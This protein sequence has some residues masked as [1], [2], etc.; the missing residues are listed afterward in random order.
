MSAPAP[1]RRLL[2]LAVSPSHPGGRSA[3][4]CHYRC[5]DACSKPVPNTTDN[6]YFGDI[7]AASASR[8]TILK[9]AGLAAAFVGFGAASAM[10][11][12]AAPATAPAAGAPRTRGRGTSPFGFTPIEPVPAGTDKVVVPEGFTWSTIIAWGDPILPGA[13]EFDF[14][15][16]S[17]AA[18][19]GQFGYNNDYTTLI[20]GKSQN[21]ATLVCNNEY[22]ND[23]LMF[24]GYTGSASL[25]PEQI[26]IT[27]AAHG[28]S[29][30]AV[31]RKSAKAEWSYVRGATVNRRVT[32]TTPFVVDGPAAGSR[33]LRTSADPSGTRVLGTFGNCAGGTT[34]WGTVISG[35]ENFNGYF[36]AATAPAD[37]AAAYQRYGL[38]GSKGRGWERVDGRFDATQEPNEVN[39]FGWVVELDPSDPTST[40]VKH[41]AMGRMKHE[42]AN[43]T[44][45]PD[46]R[47]VA[48]MGDD[49][50]FDYLYKFVSRDTF[51][52]GNSPKA[53]KHNLGLLSEGDLYVAKFTGDGFEDGIS[54][55]SG[56]WLAITKDGK[57]QVPGMSLE[58]VLVWTRLAADKLGATKMDRPEDVEP[59]LVNGR[60]YVVCTNN[61]RRTPS[62][63]DEANPRANNKHGHIIEITPTRG[64]DTQPT[65]AWKIVL[66]AGD[67]NDPTTY[68]NGYDRSEVSPISCPDNIAFDEAGNMWIATD[69]NALGAC[70][71]MYLY[72]LEGPHKGHLQQFLSVPAYAETCGPLVTWDQRTVLAAVQHPGEE[73]G[74]SPETPLSQ[75]P[76]Q[77][78]GQPRPAV[79]QI[80]PTR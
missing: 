33:L 46:G 3:M 18:Q 14:D 47:V 24:R 8:R 9:G 6:G 73:T 56:E 27:M 23:E 58:E 70:D 78:D 37:Q 68:W 41:T 31:E 34:P 32:A 55:G 60:T 80:R 17:A 44:I 2:P 40:P 1:E 77:G 35:E 72:P 4:T 76:Y 39:R 79:I 25:T 16:Q 69:G 7:A 11:A 13:P 22:T 50:R 36:S 5:D 61:T 54:D 30:V 71:G 62:Q 51:R 65:F 74:G 64:D 66:I 42:G 12:A 15:R 10:P 43:V 48:Y 52:K 49:E 19:A 67:P 29:V 45:A 57:S 38:T 28:M 26:R 75:F 20:R 59:N 63:I 21:D 53:R